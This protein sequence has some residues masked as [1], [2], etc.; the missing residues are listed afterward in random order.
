MHY[1]ATNRNTWDGMLCQGL[2]IGVSKRGISVWAPEGE[3]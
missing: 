1:A 3:I 2:S